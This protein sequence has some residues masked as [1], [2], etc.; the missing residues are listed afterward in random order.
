MISTVTFF[1]RWNAVKQN[2]SSSWKTHPIRT[3]IPLSITTSLHH[4]FQTTLQHILYQS[5]NLLILRLSIKIG[6]VSYENRFEAFGVSRTGV[7]FTGFSDDG[8]GGGRGESVES[9][10]EEGS[11][12]V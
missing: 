2:S 5:P 11:G 10:T 3:T 8:R 4:R 9:G 1:G 12:E 7:G 6:N